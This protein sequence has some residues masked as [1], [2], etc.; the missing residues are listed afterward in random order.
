[1]VTDEVLAN[2]KQGLENK[3]VAEERRQA[4]EALQKAHDALE[5][6]VEKRT[7]KLAAAT[8]LLKVEQT[9]RK[10]AGEALSLAHIERKK[11]AVDVCLDFSKRPKIA[12]PVIS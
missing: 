5:R 12:I 11:K 2:V 10:Q 4:Q 9:E 8:E 3:R 7:A 6:R 1:L